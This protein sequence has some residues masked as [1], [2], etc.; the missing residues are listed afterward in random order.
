MTQGPGNR[1]FFL[2]GRG[3]GIRRG[4]MTLW[5]V[6]TAVAAV[7]VI[8]LTIGVVVG[9]VLSALSDVRRDY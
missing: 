1:A 8:A 6:V 9:V 5:L 3:F 7:A 2:P 4:T